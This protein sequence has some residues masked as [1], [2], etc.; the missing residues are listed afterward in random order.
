MLAIMLALHLGHFHQVC[1][2]YVGKAQTWHHF[3]QVCPVYVGK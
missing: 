1:P 2:V 3:I